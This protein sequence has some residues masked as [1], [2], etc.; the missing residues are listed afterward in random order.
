MPLI[1]TR[2][3]L[4][5]KSCAMPGCTHERHP[6]GLYLHA[7]CHP[8]APLDVAYHEGVLTVRCDRC[9]AHVATIAVASRSRLQ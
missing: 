4:D 2:E 9:D 8:R 5:G 6:E 1:L 3:D 7:V